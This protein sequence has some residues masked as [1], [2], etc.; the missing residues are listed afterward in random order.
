MAQTYT[1]EE[2]ARIL[3]ISVEEMKR[4]L[5]TE[6]TNLR[7]FRDGATLRFRANEIDELA[8][9]LGHSSDPDLQ[10]GDSSA[11]SGSSDDA[12]VVFDLDTPAPAAVTKTPAKKPQDDEPLIFNDGGDD[13]FDLVPDEPKTA[14]KAGPKSGI[15]AGPKSNPPKPAEPIKVADEGLEL[16]SIPEAELGVTEKKESTTRKMSK[17]GKVPVDD[18]ADFELSLESDSTEYQLKVD[19]SEEISLGDLPF[20]RDVGD[21]DGDSGIFL[22]NPTDSGIL[23]ERKGPKSN[24]KIL[25]K[26]A[27]KPQPPAKDDD[28]EIDFELSLDVAGGASSNRL[29]SKS[30]KKI[31]ADDS[32]FDLSLDDPGSQ[33]SVLEEVTSTYSQDEEKDIFETGFEIPNIDEES[34]SEAVPLEEAD[35]DL[36][37]SNFD[38]AIESTDELAAD[39][40]GSEVVELDDISTT[41]EASGIA[42]ERRTPERSGVSKS[43]TKL[44]RD[45]SEDTFD[46][47][48]L[49]ESISASKALR[50]ISPVVADNLEDADDEG[51]GVVGVAAAPVAAPWGPL[52]ALMLLPCVFILFVGGIMG[53]ELLQGMWGYHQPNKPASLVVDAVS[54]AMG[55]K[56]K[57]EAK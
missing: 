2:A 11:S 49:D 27:E 6:W 15:K 44:G 25:A 31:E 52:P 34:T 28:D 57:D 53:F 43:K 42:L 17:S 41:A 1:L 48:N 13:L 30:M 37:D 22:R 51:E 36:E 14:S 10:L 54:D 8:R 39:S 7:S 20:A 18:S 24:P 55:I 16:T 33:G 56:P 45:V 38:L 46:N 47:M 9:K 19:E 23:L 50:G 32:E 26:P 4:R 29:S 12:P 21:K 35:T 40:S 5:K 3:G